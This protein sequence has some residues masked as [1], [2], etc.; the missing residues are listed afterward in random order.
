M[1][2]SLPQ[3]PEHSFSFLVFCP[4]KPREASGFKSGTLHLWPSVVA[5][6]FC[7]SNI[8]PRYWIVGLNA[9]WK[10]GW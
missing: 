4:G 2:S 5:Q 7:V 6:L 10:Q 9:R 1:V 8:L 3:V